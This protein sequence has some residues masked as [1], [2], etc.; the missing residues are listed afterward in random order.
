MLISIIVPVYNVADYLEKCIQ[1]ILNQ[2]Y[3][4]LEIILVDDGSTDSSGKI[5]DDYACRD[6]RIKVI[7]KING[8]LSDARNAGLQIATGDYIGYVDSDDW[9]EDDMYELMVNACQQYGADVA[10]C[11]Y[12][13][14]YPDEV[15]DKSSDKIVPLS[16]EEALEVYLCGSDTMLIYNSVWSKLFSRHLVADYEFPKGKKSE[17]IMYT[18]KA[19][20]NM[21]SCVYIDKSLYNYVIGRAGSIMAVKDGKRMLE[22]ELPFFREQIKYIRD[23]GMDELSNKAAYHYYRRLMF[24]YMDCKGDAIMRAFADRIVGLLKQDK[25]IIK[26]LYRSEYVSKGDRARMKMMFFSPG[27]Y[28]ISAKAYEKIVVNLKRKCLGK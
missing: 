20:C 24:Y 22:D 5:C 17:D 13:L 4:S 6:K 2:T 3:T 12:R 21:N 25:Q 15:I 28:Y 19:F 23:R 8:G 1:S 14:V 26:I 16:R 18:T 10:A 7:H 9:I 11:R 27:L